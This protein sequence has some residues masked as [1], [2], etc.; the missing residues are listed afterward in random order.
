[1]LIQAG[2]EGVLSDIR[3]IVMCVGMCGGKRYGF[4]GLFCSEIGFTV[5][6]NHLGLK[7][8]KW[9]WILETTSENGYEV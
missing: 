8:L 1:M 3:C 4:L 9:E 2:G 7:V 5:D 6:F